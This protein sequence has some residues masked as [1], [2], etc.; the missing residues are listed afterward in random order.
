MFIPELLPKGTRRCHRVTF[1][2]EGRS[3]PLAVLTPIQAIYDEL[4]PGRPVGGGWWPCKVLGRALA[5]LTPQ[6]TPAV[7]AL[8]CL[9]P[10]TRVVFLGLAGALKKFTPGDV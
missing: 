9:E 5:V 1:F 10:G 2:G 6:G 8:C 7:D 4:G 3:T